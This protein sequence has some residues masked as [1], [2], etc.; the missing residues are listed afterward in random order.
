MATHLAWQEWS[1]PS[2]QPIWSMIR[3]M[4]ECNR[5]YAHRI[6]SMIQD[7]SKQQVLTKW[8]Q[9]EVFS[10][11]KMS[12]STH[13]MGQM[14]S[15]KLAASKYPWQSGSIR[16]TLLLEK[17]LRRKLLR[18]RLRFRQR[19]FKAARPIWR[20][21]CCMSSGRPRDLFFS[22]SNSRLFFMITTWLKE[23]MHWMS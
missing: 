17:L 5:T 1:P 20:A 23:I 9:K 12:S 10:N 3:C 15:T 22:V 11:T 4:R 13:L 2:I 18:R 19:S 8:L 14:E 6:Q 7:W 21:H 16:R